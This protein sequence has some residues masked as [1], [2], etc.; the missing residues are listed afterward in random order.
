VYYEMFDDT[1]ADAME[2]IQYE[3]AWQPVEYLI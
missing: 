1:A 3:R 2:T